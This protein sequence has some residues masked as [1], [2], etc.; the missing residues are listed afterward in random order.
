MIVNNNLI[1]YNTL[2]DKII[3]NSDNNIRTLNITNQSTNNV[4]ETGCFTVNLS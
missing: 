1:L 4:F 3:E 2:H